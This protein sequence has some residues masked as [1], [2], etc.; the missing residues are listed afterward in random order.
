MTRFGAVFLLVLAG[1]ALVGLMLRQPE[2]GSGRGSDPVLRNQRLT[3]LNGIVLYVLLVAL[4]VTVVDIRRFLI[5]HYIVGLALIPPVIL[6]LGSTGYR[7]VRYYSGS[8]PFRLA[9]APPPLLRFVVAPV[10]VLSTAAVF[11]TGLELWVFGLRFGSVWI[12]AHTLSAVVMVAA[13][14]LHLL[15]HARAGA[16]ALRDA[17]A[18]RHVAGTSPRSLV[19]ASLVCGAVFAVAAV[20]YASPF[21]S[22]FAG[23]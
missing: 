10:L 22:N 23:G 20:V 7:F 12:S 8:E 21:T 14:A 13:V 18:A 3:A 19:V 2:A 15:A 4:A 1:A 16:G 5:P 6:K 11:A 9:G 17:G